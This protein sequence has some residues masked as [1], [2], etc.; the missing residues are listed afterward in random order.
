MRFKYRKF[1]RQLKI[2]KRSA[3]VVDHDVLQED[4]GSIILWYN[5]NNME[6]HEQ[7]FELMIHEAI[8]SSIITGGREMVFGNLLYTY[9]VSDDVTLSSVAS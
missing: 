5:R 1:Y 6:L 8:I 4:L 9:E 7:K 2:S 3:S